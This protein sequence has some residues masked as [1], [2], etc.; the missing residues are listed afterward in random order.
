MMY[1]KNIQSHS[2][3]QFHLVLGLYVPSKS[4]FSRHAQVLGI[5]SAKSINP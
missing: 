2:K 4:T 1:I 5:G 3:K